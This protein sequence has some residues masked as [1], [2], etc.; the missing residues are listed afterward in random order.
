MSLTDAVTDF[1][2][3][4]ELERR[5][6]HARK[7]KKIAD[8]VAQVVTARGYGRAQSLDNFAA[9]WHQAAGS[10][11]ARFSRPGQLK[12]GV[13]AVMVTNSTMVQEL[14]FQKQAILAQLKT[15]LPDANIRDLRFRVGAID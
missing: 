10:T 15:I 14:G 2:V 11:L 4:R 6:F 8:V 5:R 3:H 1:A 9:A 12:R 13:L 7:P